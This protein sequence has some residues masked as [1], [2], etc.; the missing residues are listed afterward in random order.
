MKKLIYLLVASLAFTACEKI[1]EIEIPSDAPRLVIEG[2]ITNNLEP[3]KV[4]LTLSQPFFDQET[5]AD[6]AAASVYINE[7]GGDTVFLSHTDTGTYVSL[8][9]QQCVVGRSYKLNV[10]YQGEVYEASEELPL[11]FPLDT[12]AAF[13]LPPNDRSFPEGIYV[14]LQGQS[15]PTSDNFYQFK[16][17]RNDTTPSDDLDNDEFGSVSLLNPTFNAKDILGEIARGLLPR[18]IR[19]GVEPGDTVRVEQRAVTQQYYQFLIDLGVQQG[20]SGS[21]FDPP[22]ANPNNNLSNGALGYFSVV[23]LEKSELIVPEF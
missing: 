15:D 9:S 4:R 14:F 20:R 11:A 21:P 16:T 1:V 18:P 8:D 10:V 23:H 19:F 5:V 17:T 7:I 2:Q 13:F 6:I 3:W 22:P 12:V